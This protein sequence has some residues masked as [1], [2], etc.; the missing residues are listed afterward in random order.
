[1]GDQVN[2]LVRI[3]PFIV[4]PRDNFYE[5]VVQRNT[6]FCIKDGCS[7][8]ADEVGRYNFIFGIS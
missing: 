5:V 6:G 4:V 7:A 8:V 2:N 1:M 3:T